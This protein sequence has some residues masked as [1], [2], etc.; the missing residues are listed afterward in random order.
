VDDLFLVHGLSVVDNPLVNYRLDV[1]M[2]LDRIGVF[3]VDDVF[4][5][6]RNDAPHML[7]TIDRF[8]S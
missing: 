7:M 8:I 5:V 6:R 4:L 1:D 3:F 2:L